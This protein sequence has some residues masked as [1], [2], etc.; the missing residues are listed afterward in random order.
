MIKNWNLFFEGLEEG[1]KYENAI[2][3]VLILGISIFFIFYALIF[4]WS[5]INSC[6]IFKI[7]KI[8]QCSTIGASMIVA[9]FPIYYSQLLF[10]IILCFSYYVEG[11]PNI[12]IRPYI[13]RGII[14]SNLKKQKIEE[15]IFSKLTFEEK[16]KWKNQF[17]FKMKNKPSFIK[18]L[19]IN[20]IPYVLGLVLMV[21]LKTG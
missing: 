20:L 4:Y 16:N 2:T 1:G 6:D 5:H 9:V 18:I 17:D 10:A 15:Q 14:S 19:I 13:N 12:M 21:I 11:N 7:H 3:T 8:S